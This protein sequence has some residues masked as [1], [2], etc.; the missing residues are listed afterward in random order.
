MPLGYLNLGGVC[1]HC[2][3]TTCPQSIPLCLHSSDQNRDQVLS[4]VAADITFA[5]LRVIVEE[6]LSLCTQS[7]YRLDYDVMHRPIVDDVMCTYI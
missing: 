2:V 6:T 7:Q 4:V 1:V 5:S 3:C